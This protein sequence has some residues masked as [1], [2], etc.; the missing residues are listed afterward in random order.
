MEF[1][2]F[3]HQLNEN[4][5]LQPASAITQLHAVIL[6]LQIPL[7]QGQTINN[8]VHVLAHGLIQLPVEIDMSTPATLSSCV[9]VY[10]PHTASQQ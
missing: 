8:A 4:I 5:A 7:C 9:L 10:V 1:Y 3:N 6:L 2:A